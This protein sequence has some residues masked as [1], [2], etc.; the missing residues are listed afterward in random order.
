MG[1]SSSKTKV[2]SS[3]STVYGGL[4]R[5]QHIAYDGTQDNCIVGGRNAGWQRLV[6][7]RHD[8]SR[9]HHLDGIIVGSFQ[10]GT[11]ALCC[12]DDA[13]Y[14]TTHN[15]PA[16]ARRISS[17]GVWTRQWAQEELFRPSA[18]AVRPS[19]GLLL[20]ADPCKICIFG[21]SRDTGHV[22]EIAGIGRAEHVD[23]VGAAA[24]FVYPCG[25][26]CDAR[27]NAYIAD[28]GDSVHG[29]CVRHMTPDGLVS[30]VVGT[31]HID[32]VGALFAHRGVA[33]ETADLYQLGAI[34]VDGERGTIY[35]ARGQC[36]FELVPLQAHMVVAALAMDARLN[37]WPTDVLA[38]IVSYSPTPIASVRIVVGDPSRS[39][40]APFAD[41]TSM[42]FVPSRHAPARHETL[43][44]HPMDITAK[45]KAEREAQS[46]S[47]KT[48]SRAPALYVCAGGRILCIALA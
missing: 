21:V 10:M 15:S 25:L 39:R 4:D 7:T 9:L 32:P 47:D 33:R 34:C 31:S 20:V 48:P 13:I 45:Q 38:L 14:A 35:V 36:V 26:C 19:D 46:D 6:T 40:P 27:G 24:G 23:G 37:R 16:I 11:R 43:A 44:G 18:L 29:V 22:R 28:Y 30:T 3:V 5:F 1:G 2:K 8:T 41:I 17:S 12:D 42:A